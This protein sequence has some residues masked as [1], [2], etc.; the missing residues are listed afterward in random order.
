MDNAGVETIGQGLRVFGDDASALI[1]DFSVNVNSLNLLFGNDD[2]GFSQAGDLA[3]L[4]AFSG[5]TQV[6]QATVVLNRNDIAD[7]TIALSGFDFNRA[8]FRYERT[9]GNPLN[10]I[11]VV[12][13]VTFT[14]APAQGAIPEPGTCV[15]LGTC[16]LPLG[17]VAL[18]RRGGSKK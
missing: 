5:G 16:L 17:R 3:V 9:I 4:T 15:L 12:D 14:V 10:L 2:P 7:Q 8:T 6:G 18:R 1:M 11:E 13:N